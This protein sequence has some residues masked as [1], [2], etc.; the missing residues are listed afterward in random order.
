MMRVLEKFCDA[1]LAIVFF[2]IIFAAAILV[3]AAL[4]FQL[5]D[6]VLIM[7]RRTCTKENPYTKERDASEPGYGWQHDALHED[8]GSQEDGYPGG[9]IVTMHCDNCGI[10]FKVELPQ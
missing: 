2:L 5:L 6:G 8:H 10:K 1:V 9:D 7:T 4:I 3:L